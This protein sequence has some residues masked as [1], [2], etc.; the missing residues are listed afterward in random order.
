MTSPG[1][2]RSVL[3]QFGNGRYRFFLPMKGIVEVERL[4]KKPIGVLYDELSG[5]IGLDKTTEAPV[6]LIGGTA[7]ITD[8]YHLIRKAAE[9]GGQAEIS[10]ETVKISS[11]D[12]ANLV[13]EYVDGKDYDEFMP[14]AWAIAR[15]TLSGATLKKKAEQAKQSPLAA[16][17]S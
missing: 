17:K 5:S 11:I 12:A 6:Y 1:A 10:G 8:A 16:D 7:S 4:C 14:V 2:E 15:H 13:D 9:Y 3:I